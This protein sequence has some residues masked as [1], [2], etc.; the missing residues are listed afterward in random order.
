MQ[1]SNRPSWHQLY[2]SIAKLVAKR[3]LDEHT[4][5]GC[6]IVKDNR[7]IAI[8]YNG[9]PK[10]YDKT[11]DWSSKDKYDYVVHAE[12]NAI[13]NAS[14]NNIS[15]AG[16]EV[17]VT[18]APCHECIKM[19]IQNEVKTVYYRDTYSDFELTKQIA[20]E[21]GLRLISVYDISDFKEEKR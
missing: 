3:S 5:V 4:K 21:C 15:C 7:L 13:C 17:Y 14:M 10:S 20:S 8:G 16:S 18:L 12:M 6:C 9:A 2:F 1:K 11:I 19:L